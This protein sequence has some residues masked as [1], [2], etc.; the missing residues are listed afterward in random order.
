MSQRVSG[1]E[2]GS[3]LSE[4]EE[5]VRSVNRDVRA[6][7]DEVGLSKAGSTLT[8]VAVEAG[9][10]V[11]SHVGD[12]RLYEYERSAG[13]LR[14]RTVDHNL[15]SELK[16]LGESFTVAAEQGLPLNGLVSYIGLPDKD[17]RVDVFSWSPAPGTRLL[18]CSD[19]V[20]SYLS[21]SEITAVIAELPAA[22]AASELTRRADEVGGR[23]NATAIVVELSG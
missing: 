5:M 12:S 14:Q 23:D 15:R 10:A 3:P 17:L 18:L 13:T 8:M 19:G 22:E 20:H 4:W 21:E 7:A 6:K 16:A 9:R 11:A 1:I 2:S